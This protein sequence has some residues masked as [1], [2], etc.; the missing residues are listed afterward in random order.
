MHKPYGGPPGGHQDQQP[1]MSAAGTAAGFTDTHQAYPGGHFQQYP[2]PGASTNLPPPPGSIKVTTPTM[3]IFSFSA[4]CSVMVGAFI[5][6]VYFLTAGFHLIRFVETCYIMLFGGVLAV[7][8]TPFFKTFHA[9][10][11]LKMYIRKYINLITRATGEGAT[12]VFLGCSLLS[13]SLAKFDSPVWVFLEIL[14]CLWPIMIGLGT[15]IIGVM[16]SQKLNNARLKLLAI[17]NQ[18]LLHSKYTQFARTCP[19][20]GLTKTEFC[21]LVRETASLSFED[22]ELKLIFNVLVSNPTWRSTAPAQVGNDEAKMPK[23]DLF[24]WIQGGWVLL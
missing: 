18:G 4:A 6:V 15:I 7:L 5:G 14:L 8:E 3:T 23:E 20:I 10:N 16:K 19:E 9:I 17:D 2:V 21:E 24:S 22:T 13:T 1:L 11:Q 12:F